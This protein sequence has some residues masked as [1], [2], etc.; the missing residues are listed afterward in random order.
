MFQAVLDSLVS[1]SGYPV[2]WALAMVVGM[3]V[4]AAALYL[5]WDLVW[6]GV[7]LLGRAGGARRRRN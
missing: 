3:A 4:T 2:L 7:S 6:R 5:F 1:L